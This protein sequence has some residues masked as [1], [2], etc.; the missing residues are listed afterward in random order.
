MGL[1]KSGTNIGAAL[2]DIATGLLQDADAHKGYDGVILFFICISSLAVVAGTVLYILDR[3][4]YKSVLDRSARE[5][6]HSDENKLNNSRPV[7]LTPLKANYIY[8]SIY[9]FLCCLSW[10]LFFRFILA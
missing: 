7:P 1:I 8:G 10:L 6:Y 3:T 5:A 2:F 9:F 4:I